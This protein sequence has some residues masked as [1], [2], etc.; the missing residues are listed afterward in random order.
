MSMKQIA[1]WALNVANARGA[2][3]ADVR[4]VDERNRALSTKNGKVA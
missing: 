1:E 3:Y 2:D 4:L